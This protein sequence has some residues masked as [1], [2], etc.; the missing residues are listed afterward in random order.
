MEIYWLTW[1]QLSAVEQL[2]YEQGLLPGM[3]ESAPLPERCALI[4]QNR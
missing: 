3:S 4:V 2:A 1:E